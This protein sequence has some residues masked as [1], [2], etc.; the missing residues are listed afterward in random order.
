MKKQNKSGL[1]VLSIVV[2]MSIVLGAMNFIDTKKENAVQPVHKD[3]KIKLR[4]NKNGYIAKLN[5]EGV[6][7][8]HN[9]SYNQEWLLNTIKA[10]KDDAS[11][12]AIAL[13]IDSP[14]G[15]VYEA[16]AVYLALQDYKTAGKKIYAYQGHLAASGG[17]YIS[18]AA[19]K[20]YAN[21]NTLTGSIGVISGT[22]FDITELLSKAGIKSKTI[23]AGKNKNMFNYNEPLTAEQEKIMQGVCDSYYERFVNI[24]AQNRNM[25]ND[26]VKALA[27]GR[28]YTAKQA[29]DNGLIDSIDSWENMITDIKKFEFENTDLSVEEFA[30]QKDFSFG[31]LFMEKFLGSEGTYAFRKFFSEASVSY[32]AYLAIF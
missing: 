16:D 22:S 25:K 8:S 7:Q 30:Y 9:R 29:L 23:H 28:I 2:A 11:N 4:K 12:K 24:V 13:F 6:I 3:M 32:P 1:L 14:G 26:E 21:R 5:I 20:I 27:D 31:D 17:Y 15:T 10:L 19:N 18:C